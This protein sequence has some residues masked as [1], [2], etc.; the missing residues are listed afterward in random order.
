MKK[1]TI[2]ALHLGFGGVEKSIAS[3][4][5]MLYKTK[6]YN[7]EIISVYKLYDKP[8]F[9]IA[10]GVSITYLLDYGPN[11]KEFKEAILSK[12]I[13][14][15]FKEGIKGI[16]LLTLKYLKT[17]KA[18]KNINSDYII[19]TRYLHNKMV[20]KYANKNIIKIAEEHNNKLYDK[21]YTTNVIK[22]LKNIDYFAPVSKQLTQFYTSKLIK[23]NNHH[24]KVVYIP[25]SIGDVP[26]IESSSKNHNIISVGRL[27][28]EKGME[29]LVR[30]FAQILKDKKYADWTLSIIGDG[31]EMKNLKD[32]ASS[33]NVQD[34]VIFTG[35]LEK[36]SLEQEYIQSS[37]YVMLSYNES[38]GLVLV[39]AGSYA[40]PVLAYE[41]AKGP[42][43]I[44]QDGVNGYLIDGRNEDLMKS[45]LCQLMDNETLRYNMGQAGK[46]MALE[47]TNDEVTRKWVELLK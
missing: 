37:I 31:S 46:K 3:L 33:L 13:F 20:G 35:F 34:K 39:E 16:K 45:K 29:D 2:L 24:T 9:E 14:K 47:Y 15:I 4:A 1:V 36:A 44:I 30:M 10:S 41:S 22:S 32:L 40:V 7:V 21:K 12:N 8:S 26:V 11:R 28:K 38:F 42:Q 5:N 43:E 27:E 6:Q 18:I 23:Y 19:T 25:N 17:K